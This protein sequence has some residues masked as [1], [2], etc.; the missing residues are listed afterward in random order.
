MTFAAA[1]D[2]LLDASGCCPDRVARSEW[3]WSG[4]SWRC[5]PCLVSWVDRAVESKCWSCG[6]DGER[7][8]LVMY[9]SKIRRSR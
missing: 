7:G 8:I 1:V 4:P 6:G 3:G 9:P 2:G 5:E